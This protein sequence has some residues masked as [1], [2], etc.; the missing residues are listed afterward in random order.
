MSREKELIKNTIVLS[1][2]KLLP[3]LTSFI[4]LPILTA[5][6][7]KAEYGT[8]DLISTLL[9]L[10]LPIAT[11]QVQA[12]AFRFLIDCRGNKKESSKIISNIWVAT[13]PVSVI[14]SFII[15]FF[16]MEY[17]ISFRAVLVLYFFMDTV[18]STIGQITRGLG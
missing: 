15:Q 11:L 17:S 2:G 9:M 6:L 14:V 5:Y 16:F 7:T 13:V 12:A 3:K 1:F 4:T 18:N 8:Y 10:L